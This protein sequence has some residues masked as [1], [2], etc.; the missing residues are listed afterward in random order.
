MSDPN[1]IIGIIGLV[2]ILF[3]PIVVIY[4]VMWW[5]GGTL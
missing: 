3:G 4:V 2:T 5:R 1:H